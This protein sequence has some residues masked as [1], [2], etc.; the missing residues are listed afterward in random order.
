[1]TS[2]MLNGSTVGVMSA[3]TIAA[4]TMAKRHQLNS[5]FAVRIFNL[6]RK[7]TISGSS[8]ATPIQN[9]SDVTKGMYAD[10]RQ[11]VLKIS[12][13]KSARK[14]IA[15]GSMMPQAKATPNKNKKVAPGTMKRTYR[16]SLASKPG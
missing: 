3:A 5:F 9:M 11:L 13:W 7:N 14:P 12:G 1:M 6:A 8:K 16:F 2:A 15:A 10:A 4:P